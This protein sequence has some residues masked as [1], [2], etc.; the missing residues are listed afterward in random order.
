MHMNAPSDAMPRRWFT[1]REAASILGM[2]RQT[3]WRRVRCGEL[4]VMRVDEQMV[5]PASQLKEL[6]ANGTLR[7][8]AYRTRAA[9][10]PA[11]DQKAH[12]T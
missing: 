12:C 9:R 11:R 7:A 1:V 5:I 4:K 6:L 3:L 8:R 10:H 2:S